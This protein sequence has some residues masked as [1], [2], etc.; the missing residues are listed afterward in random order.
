MTLYIDEN[1]PSQLAKAFDL[2]QEPLNERNNTRIRVR[3]LAET[4][5][6]GVKDEEWIPALGKEPSCIITQDFNIRRTRHLKALC[7]QYGLGMFFIRP[8]SKKGL[9]YWGFVRLLTRHWEEMVRIA[10]PEK[11]PFAYRMSQ[12]SSRLEKLD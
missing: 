10:T 8:P 6:R 3:S 1:L 5:Q 9:P 4:F 12:R 2:L 11:R 7:G